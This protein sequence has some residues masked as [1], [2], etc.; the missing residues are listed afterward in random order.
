VV[1]F[2]TDSVTGAPEKHVRTLEI[3]AAACTRYR[4][5]AHHT[6][7]VH[8]EWAPVVYPEPIGECTAK[9]ASRS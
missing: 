8:V 7:L 5:V 9:F 2:S 4:I 1:H 3:E 6:T